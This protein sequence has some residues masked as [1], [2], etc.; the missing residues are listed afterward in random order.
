M[1]L[2]DDVT[3]FRDWLTLCKICLVTIGRVSGAQRP[4][5]DH[6][7]DAPDVRTRARTQRVDRFSDNEVRQPSRLQEE[8]AR[9]LL[10]P[11]VPVSR[12]T[13]TPGEA[14]LCEVVSTSAHRALLARGWPVATSERSVVERSSV[15]L[16]V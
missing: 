14:S 1:G 15:T 12:P 3:V 4:R 13:L 11:S 16:S 6:G 2:M 10:C 7:R 9:L 5:C 8:D